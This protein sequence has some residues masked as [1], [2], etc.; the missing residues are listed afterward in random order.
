MIQY[1]LTKDEVI[2]AHRT[3][4]R[5]TPNQAL[6]LVAVIGTASVLLIALLSRPPESERL[7]KL[8]AWLFAGFVVRWVSI[9]FTKLA[10]SSSTN[11]T[12]PTQVSFAPD[13]LTYTD[14]RCNRTTRWHWYERMIEDERFYY[15]LRGGWGVDPIPKRAFDATSQE[16]FLRYSQS[17]PRT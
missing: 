1:Q 11:F 12:P 15:L 10:V 5:A 8:G 6:M 16:E 4:R 17:I 14:P 13:C 9:W 7:F 2:N 3:R